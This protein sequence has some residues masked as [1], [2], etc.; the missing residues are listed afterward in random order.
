MEEV[1]GLDIDEDDDLDE[2]DDIQA[3][4]VFVSAIQ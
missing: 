4:E 3:H 2:D 1:L